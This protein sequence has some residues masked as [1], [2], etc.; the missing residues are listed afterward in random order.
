VVISRYGLCVLAF[1]WCCRPILAATQKPPLCPVN[2][3]TATALERPFDRGAWSVGDLLAIK[4]IGP[5]AWKKCAS[6]SRRQE[7]R[8]EEAGRQRG[9]VIHVADNLQIADTR[10][11]EKLEAKPATSNR[12]QTNSREARPEDRLRQNERTRQ[13]IVNTKFLSEELVRFAWLIDAERDLIGDR[14]AVTF[15]SYYFLRVIR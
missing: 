13:G 3:N 4:G 9:D 7:R 12:D 14:D 11:A 1:L 8:A 5:N 6:T 2:L 15:Q 10:G